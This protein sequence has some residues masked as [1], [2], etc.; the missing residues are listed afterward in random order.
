VAAEESFIAAAK[1]L[2]RQFA[3]KGTVE[4]RK[5]APHANNAS[6]NAF[7]LKY[8]IV[9]RDEFGDRLNSDV[10]LAQ[11][12]HLLKGKWTTEAHVREMLDIE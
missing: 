1:R 10:T 9:L 7:R 2:C 6:G 8:Q 4:I 12:F 5:V 3:Q 11:D